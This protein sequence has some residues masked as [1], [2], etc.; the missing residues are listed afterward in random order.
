[1]YMAATRIYMLALVE[2]RLTG[3]QNQRLILRHHALHA[4]EVRLI[5]HERET[6][7]QAEPEPWFRDF[8]ATPLPLPPQPFAAVEK[9]GSHKKEITSIMGGASCDQQNVTMS[10]P[11]SVYLASKLLTGRDL[12]DSASAQLH[13]LK[14]SRDLTQAATDFC[15]NLRT[16]SRL[17]R[18]LLRASDA[19]SP[20]AA[21]PRRGHR[22]ALG[23]RPG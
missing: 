11:S 15:R 23:P 5:W 13:A 18:M 7:F 9:V 20:V 1:M 6:T 21:T 14:M 8:L 3:E 10:H 4:R 16:V 19:L 2:D 12:G 17:L 22:S